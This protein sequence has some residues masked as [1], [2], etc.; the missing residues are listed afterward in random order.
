MILDWDVHHGN[1]TDQVFHASNQVLFVSIHQ[2][3]LFPGTGPAYDLGEGA[4]RGFTINLPVLPGSGDEVGVSLVE[5]VVV[6]LAHAFEPQLV[7]GLRGIRRASRR[8]ARGLRRDRSGVR[9]DGACCGPSV[10]VAVGAG[11]RRAGGRICARGAG[12]LGGGD[13]SGVFGAGQ[14]RWFG[15]RSGGG[16]GADRARGARSP[17]RVV[18]A[19]RAAKHSPRLGAGGS[20]ICLS[21]RGVAAAPTSSERLDRR[22]TRARVRRRL[23]PSAPSQRR[24][25]RV[26]LA[27]VRSAAVET[28]ATRRKRKRLGLVAGSIL[29]DQVSKDSE[30]NATEPLGWARTG[31]DEPLGWVVLTVPARGG[32]PMARRSSERRLT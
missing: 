19:A 1:S 12:T 21:R 4:G 3:P 17:R 6:P 2:S 20:T 24:A 28:T 26:Y 32:M 18:A 8:S 29:A 30:T 23:R 16:R 27:S 5:H 7:L 14:R 25:C 10:P 22:P 9:G 31:R 13:A 15:S 11:R